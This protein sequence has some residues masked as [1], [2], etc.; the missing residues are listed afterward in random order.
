MAGEVSEDRRAV[1]M[2]IVLERR[3]KTKKPTQPNFNALE[4]R[5][6]NF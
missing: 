1:S 5:G 2:T 4:D 6:G 3:K